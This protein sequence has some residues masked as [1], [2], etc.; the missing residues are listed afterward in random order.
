MTDY[1]L[2][3]I[4][5]M[6]SPFDPQA[7]ANDPNVLEMRARIARIGALMY[8]RRLTD[9]AG[10]NISA[11]VSTPQGEV[12]CMSP[13]YAG[14]RYLWALTP[15]LVLVVDADGNILVGDGEISRE[16]KAHLRL[17]RV[18]H[19]AGTSVI[20]AHARNVLAFA[21]M[22][23]PMFPVLEATRKFGEV[24]VIR[25]AP[26]HSASL[27]EHIAEA[28]AGREAA[29][30]KQGVGVIAPWHGLFVMGKDLNA[31]YDAVERIDTQ[32]YIY[33]MSARAGASEGLA[34]ERQAM[35]DAIANF[36]E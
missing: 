10:G 16:S 7:L 30:A 5:L 36:A 35:E 22:A 34:A 23:R 2:V 3:R 29:I 18:F 33:L 17:H 27:S 13:R 4:N 9:T 28:M 24:P 21:A 6:T 19:E 11:R 1:A 26:S 14:S 20:H 32:A 12:I 31:A 8:D 15:D 25:F